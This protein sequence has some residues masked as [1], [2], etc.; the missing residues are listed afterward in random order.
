MSNFRHLIPIAICFLCFSMPLSALKPP[1]AKKDKPAEPTPLDIYIKDAMRNEHDPAK[2]PT[3]S[4]WSPG[5]NLVDLGSDLRASHVDDL[6]TVVVSEQASA[7]STGTTK[8][9]RT[10]S[11]QA[12]VSSLGGVKSA[13]GA[14]ANLAK[15]STDAQ[16]NG[17]GSTG[18][19]TTL[20]TTISARVTHVLPNGYLVI[21][22]N[23]QVQVN[24]EH[25]DVSIRGVI[26]PIDLTTNN[27]I[28]SDAIAQM[29]LRINGKGVVNDAIRR[30]NFLYRLIL[31]IL[32]F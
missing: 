8:T 25:Q 2:N 31:G 5:S 11:L 23:K 3:G 22:G 17:Q 21:E 4:I 19:T 29:E 16:L 7:V 10:S 27:Q 24:S 14:L 28:A 12:S 13:T 32:P 30:P 20:T 15:S 18:R 26:R 6:V 9:G 1:K